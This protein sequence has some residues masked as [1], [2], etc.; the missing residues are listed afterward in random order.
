M[1]FFPSPEV[2]FAGTGISPDDLEKGTS[3][4][5]DGGVLR[6]LISM[7]LSSVPID[8]E[9]YLRYPDLRKAHLA[10][11]IGDV[12]SHYFESGFFEKR[13]APPADFDASW[14]LNQYIDVQI[15]VRT[16]A[17]ESALSHYL[18]V[19]AGEWRAPSESSG[20]DLSAWFKLLAP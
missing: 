13:V 2:F 5:I 9:S 15:A 20:A 11:Q 6:K 7:A 10:G 12:S 4:S 3:V 19:G 17:S 8:E 18:E 1:A 14:Y 16:G